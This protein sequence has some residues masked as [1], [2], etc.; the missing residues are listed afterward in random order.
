MSIRNDTIEKADVIMA[1]RSPIVGED[2]VKSIVIVKAAYQL[3][4]KNLSD[5]KYK[6]LCDRMDDPHTDEEVDKIFSGVKAIVSAIK[7]EEDNERELK[8]A[9][10]PDYLYYDDKGNLKIEMMKYSRHLQATLNIIYYP[11]AHQL[12]T[13]DAKAHCYRSENTGNEI[14]NSIV[15][16]LEERSM[17]SSHL[18]YISDEIVK[19]LKSMDT[20]E[21]YP[22][23]SSV[24]TL[25]VENGILEINY[26]TGR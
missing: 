13:Y 14:D 8:A 15:K 11:T 9:E 2:R 23:N 24:N 5:K 16:M 3:R 1:K 25:P 26:K 7:L 18:R 17:D 10:L 4:G 21:E 12:F 20:A 6:E 19:H 22:F